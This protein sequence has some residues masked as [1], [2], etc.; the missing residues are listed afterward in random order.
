M[1]RAARSAL[2]CG[3]TDGAQKGFF[4]LEMELIEKLRLLRNEI[5]EIGQVFLRDRLRQIRKESLE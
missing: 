2:H 5:M 1:M 4:G 3:T